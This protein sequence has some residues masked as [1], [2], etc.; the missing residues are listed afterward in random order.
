[1]DLVF[2]KSSSSKLQPV[3]HANAEQQTAV[4]IKNL[5]LSRTLQNRGVQHIEVLP[6][7]LDQRL[8]ELSQQP[9]AKLLG[10]Q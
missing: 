5:I 3:R 6:R 1:M 2:E 10:L 4:E 7:C 9:A 8:F